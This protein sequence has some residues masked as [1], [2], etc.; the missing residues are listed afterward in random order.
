MTHFTLYNRASWFLNALWENPLSYLSL[1]CQ[2]SFKVL[3]KLFIK[4][5]CSVVLL[6]LTLCEPVD[7][8]LPVFSAHVIFSGKNSGVGC[9]FLLQGI[10]LTQESNLG[11]LHC[12]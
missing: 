3:K 10:F 1:G 6:C 7:C 5:M 4:C 11:L 9:H 8:T 2:C 12:R